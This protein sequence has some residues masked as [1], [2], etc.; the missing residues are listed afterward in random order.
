MQ[1][2]RHGFEVPEDGGKGKEEMGQYYDIVH[3]QNGIIPHKSVWDPFLSPHPSP[4]SMPTCLPDREELLSKADRFCHKTV[5]SR[6]F[7]NRVS[8]INFLTMP[9]IGVP[10][11]N[12]VML[13]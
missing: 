4:T 5:L 2:H 9:F 6:F 12:V 13:L 8:N 3:V 10:L 7:F 11:T 1:E